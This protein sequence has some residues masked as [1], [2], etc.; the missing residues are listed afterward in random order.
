MDIFLFNS[1]IRKPHKVN[2]NVFMATVFRE[3]L[4]LNMPANILKNIAHL[5][6]KV[7]L[8]KQMLAKSR[9]G[10]APNILKESRSVDCNMPRIKIKSKNKGFL[11]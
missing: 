4:S 10:F 11:I 2:N 8:A 9:S 7:K 3:T 1:I 6:G 5:K